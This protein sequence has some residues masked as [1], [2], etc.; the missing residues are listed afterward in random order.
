MG[1]H[2]STKTRVAPIFDQLYMNDNSGHSWIPKL[3]SLPVGGNSVRFSVNCDFTIQES[4]W[5]DKE[6]QLD[7]PVALLSWLIR[8]PRP[9]LSG[10]LSSDPDKALKRSEWIAGSETR[11]LEG[12]SLLRNNPNG[13]DWHLF[14]GQTQPDVFIQTPD[15]VVVIEGKRTE[16]GPTTNTKWMAG[17]HQ[18]LRHIDCAWEVAGNRKIIGFF[19][20]EGTDN[21]RLVPTPW[22]E[23]ARQTVAPDAVASSLPHRG[24]EEQNGIASCFA[25][26]TTWQR[27]CK[28]LKQN[29]AALP[30][31]FHK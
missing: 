2:N 17:R 1:K 26:V 7:P 14:E 24:L 29:W 20:V 9:P 12:L 18:M 22:I 15:V 8:H 11:R 23:Y 21:D 13:E 10:T 3:I 5:G 25:G 4:M 16:R 31:V 30:D 6:K 28:E 27:L 19:I